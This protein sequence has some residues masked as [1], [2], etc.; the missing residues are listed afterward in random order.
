MADIISEYNKTYKQD[1]DNEL[2]MQVF[3]DMALSDGQPQAT[4]GSLRR[5]I[6]KAPPVP[7]PPKPPFETPKYSREIFLPTLGKLL[8]DK[9]KQA[10]QDKINSIRNDLDYIYPNPYDGLINEALEDNFR[11]FFKE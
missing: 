10:T 9:A 7:Y 8:F 2:A 5:L 6:P 1:P 11:K 3:M 4:A